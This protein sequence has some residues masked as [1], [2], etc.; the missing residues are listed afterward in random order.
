MRSTEKEESLVVGPVL[1]IVLR[2][3]ISRFWEI[4]N[5]DFGGHG[6]ELHDIATRK[7]T[8]AE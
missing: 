3:D 8:K 4:E 1:G 6:V 5:W 2:V 7:L